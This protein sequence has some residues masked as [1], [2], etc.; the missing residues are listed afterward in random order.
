M[1]CVACLSYLS[2]ANVAG[3]SC[4]CIDVSVAKTGAV[5]AGGV[6]REEGDAR[7]CI[8]G[9]HLGRSS[10]PPL[11]ARWCGAPPPPALCATGINTNNGVRRW[12]MGAWSRGG[13]V[14]ARAHAN[15]P[16]FSVPQQVQHRSHSTKHVLLPHTR[17][18]HPTR[19]S[20]PP[21]SACTRVEA[22]ASTKCVDC[23][24]ACGCLTPCTRGSR[25]HQQV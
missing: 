10:A 22:R 8:S 9:W 6:I 13:S 14:G 24:R 4:L 2:A 1:H 16:I 11:S 25:R 5:G 17:P 12:W 7:A 19:A 3:G 20:S 21:L 23:V 18:L 15:T